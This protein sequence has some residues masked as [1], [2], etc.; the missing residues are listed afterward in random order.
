MAKARPPLTRSEIMARIGGRDT[1]P[2]LAVR[3]ALHAAGFRYRLGLTVCGTRPDLVFPGRKTV[4]FVDGCLWHGCPEHYTAPRTNQP[5]WQAKLARNV[6]RDITQT[7]TLRAAGWAVLRLWEHALSPDALAET[8]AALADALN[9]DLAA[10]ARFRPGPR[11]HQVTFLPGP[12]NRESWVL[13][14]MDDDLRLVIERDRPTRRPRPGPR[15]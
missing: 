11:V 12:D 10:L 8:I 15:P 13:W 4:V 7:G 9:G 14:D 6:E 3:R 2:E 5:F 1:S